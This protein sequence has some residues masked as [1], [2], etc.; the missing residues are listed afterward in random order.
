M[1]KF[2]TVKSAIFV[3]ALGFILLLVSCASRWRGS[4][5]T[6]GI[7]SYAGDGIIQD[8]SESAWPI[9][10]RGYAILFPKFRL[11]TSYS[12]SFRLEGLPIIEG[13]KIGIYF[14]VDDSLPKES[15]IIAN[16]HI[17]LTVLDSDSKKVCDSE[18]I[19]QDFTWSSP[20]HKYSGH[21]LYQQDH[22]F[23]TPIPN[24][25]YRL[26]VSYSPGKGASHGEGQIYLTCAVG[27]K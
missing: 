10:T 25:S 19:L 14:L 2:R 15:A 18:G 6:S 8:T 17:R 5:F 12:N 13:R 7:K 23:F 11:D 24:Q 27:G 3:V 20:W 16:A 1:I 21:A 22:S 26:S 9:S 4:Y